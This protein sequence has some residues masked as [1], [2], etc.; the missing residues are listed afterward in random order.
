MVGRMRVNTQDLH[1]AEELLPEAEKTKPAN[2][3]A[4]LLKATIL[5]KFFRRKNA[6]AGGGTS[7]KRT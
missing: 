1:E 6:S 2:G 5:K 3:F 4:S 7:G